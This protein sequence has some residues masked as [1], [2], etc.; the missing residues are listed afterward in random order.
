LPIRPAVDDRRQRFRF[1]MNTD[2]R[3]QVAK[4][5]RGNP[6]RGEGRVADISSKALAFHTDRP[7]E[8]GARLNVSMAWPAKLDDTMLRLAFEG[9]VLRVR[10]T[11][12]VV[13]I[14]RTEFRTAGRATSAAREEFA[15]AGGSMDSPGG[16]A[17]PN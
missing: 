3:Y 9:T 10:G 12:V 6:V 11:L 17:A 8:S 7:I 13:S 14:E 2:L 4:R 1:Q 16:Q 5:D 15:A